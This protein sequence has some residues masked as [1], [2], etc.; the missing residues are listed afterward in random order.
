[1][2]RR[3][4]KS[5]D[6]KRMAGFHKKTI[7]FPCPKTLSRDGRALWRKIVSAYP[8]DYFRA[9]DIPLLQAYCMEWER[10]ARAQR[11]L[12]EGGEVIGTKCNPWHKILNV[13][14]RSGCR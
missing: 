12:I 1:M 4:P 9:G 11:M 7:A 8:A 3:G 6:Q 2:G 5:D 14:N 10:H 13:Q